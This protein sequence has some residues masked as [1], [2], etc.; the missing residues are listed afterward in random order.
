[1]PPSSG[2][3]TLTA[4]ELQ[5]LRPMDF[6]D[7][8]PGLPDA[9]RRPNRAGTRA[10]TII[11]CHDIWQGFYLGKEPWRASEFALQSA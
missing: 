9:S 2:G 1:M 7:G 4:Q 5:A 3:P 8:A 6:L 10:R 11:P